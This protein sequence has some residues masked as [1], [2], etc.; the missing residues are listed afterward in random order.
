MT[1]K[2]FK[3]MVYIRNTQLLSEQGHHAFGC[4]IMDIKHSYNWF[5]DEVGETVKLTNEKNHE[6]WT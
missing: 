4:K 1:V 3:K 2:A 5:P 6:W